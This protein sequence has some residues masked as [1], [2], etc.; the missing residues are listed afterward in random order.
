MENAS[1]ALILAGEMLIGVIVLG[2]LSFLFVSMGRSSK[3]INN[4]IETDRVLVFNNHFTD[5]NGRV[6]ITANEIV[7]VLNFA[8][9]NNKDYNID[10][11]SNSVYYVDVLVDNVSIIDYTKDQL[12]EFLKNNNIN[13]F[14]CNAKFTKQGNTITVKY[15]DN[16]NITIDNTTSLVTKIKFTSSNISGFDIV[17]KDKFMLKYGN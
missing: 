13:Y 17:N 15:Q 3:K 12:N 9:K 1:K 11:N 5:F 7:T 10:K 14:K 8:K 6:D 4:Q 2:L 16:G